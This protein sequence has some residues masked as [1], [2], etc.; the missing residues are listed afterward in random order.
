MSIFVKNV[1]AIRASQPLDNKM[2][3]GLETFEKLDAYCKQLH[4]SGVLQ[5]VDTPQIRDDMR[6]MR[7]QSL[8]QADFV[9]LTDIQMNRLAYAVR[10]NMDNPERLRAAVSVRGG[11]ALLE[12]LKQRGI[13]EAGFLTQFRD[14]TV[15]ANVVSI[16]EKLGS[17]AGR[18]AIAVDPMCATGNSMAAL[19]ENVME[20]RA[21]AVTVVV[22]FATPQ[23]IH[24][25]SE[26]EGVDRIISFPLEAGITAPDKNG[27]HAN[28]VVGG[29]GKYALLDDFSRRY[30]GAED[31]EAALDV[32]SAVSLSDAEM[33]KQHGIFI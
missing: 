16:P 3:T 13:Y 20:R 6:S 21:S 30:F 2:P 7:D 11:L 15:E 28:Y 29:I 19:V 8:S 18:R 31:G 25:V 26:L 17:F 10:P 32:L 22:A 33:R 9:G 12:P 14:H 23:G 5:I 4:D 27:E 1:D 24:K